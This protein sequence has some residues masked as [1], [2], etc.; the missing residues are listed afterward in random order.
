[1]RPVYQKMIVAT[2][3]SPT[4][5]KAVDRAV[6]VARD[7][8][9]TLTIMSAGSPERAG[10]VVAAEQSRLKNSDVPIDTLTVDGEPSSAIVDA[11]AKGNFDV[12]VVGNR[13]MTGIRRFITLGAVPNKVS[14]HLPCS[15]LIVKTT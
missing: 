7:H 5:A 1:M 12:L 10:K 15:L 3:G 2:D 9:A 6:E 8:G 4:A 14:H 11:A 13:G